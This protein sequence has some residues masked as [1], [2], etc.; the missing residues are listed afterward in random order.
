[1]KFVP[2]LGG[3]LGTGARPVGEATSVRCAI[4]AIPL[5]VKIFPFH[6]KFLRHFLKI[7]ADFRA[8]QTLRGREQGIVDETRSFR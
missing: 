6:R 3:L 4:Q 2:R 7:C 8:P 5:E 1:M